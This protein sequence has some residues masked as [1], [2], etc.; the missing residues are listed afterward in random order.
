MN[1][2]YLEILFE[3]K[4]NYLDILF[5]LKFIMVFR[6]LILANM[7][8]DFSSN[9]MQKW[10]VD[11]IFK[12]NMLL[13]RAVDHTDKDVLSKDLELISQ[14][15]K[16]DDAYKSYYQSLYQLVINSYIAR[17]NVQ[18]LAELHPEGDNSD[19]NFKTIYKKQLE[20]LIDNL[21]N[22]KQF[23]IKFESEETL[24]KARIRSNKGNNISIKRISIIIIEL[25]MS[26]IKYSR[27]HVNE[28]GGD[29]S[30]DVYIYQEKE[31]LVIKNKV[32]TVRTI[33]EINDDIKNSL[34]RKKAGFSLAAIKECIDQFYGLEDE[35][36]VLVIA[37]EEQG[38]K[39]YHVKLPILEG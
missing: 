24:M 37:T 29:E 23:D 11:Q 34:D 7:K 25:V 3:Q 9:L 12:K 28:N 22:F 33:A 14:P 18:T 8:K 13:S 38:E 32:E 17:I 10:G 5:A 30:V 15:T 6:D 16:I 2:V 19:P 36:G 31:Y 4:T 39:F 27:T 35:E 1:E 21:K 20:V 26:A